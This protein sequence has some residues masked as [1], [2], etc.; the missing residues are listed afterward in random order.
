MFT[1]KTH[2]EG[3]WGYTARK[4]VITVI[5]F[6]LISLMIF[7]FLH[8]TNPIIIFGPADPALIK[9]LKHE[10]GLDKPLIVYYFRWIGDFF[11]RDWGESIM[12]ESYYSK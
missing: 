9:E 2:S 5:L 10:L 11:T 7:F 8:L 1:V 12:G 3:I 6:F 4:I